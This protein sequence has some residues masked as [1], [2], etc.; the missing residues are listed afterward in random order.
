MQPPKL[1]PALELTLPA[2]LPDT[3]PD[4]GAA[5]HAIQRDVLALY[6]EHAPRLCE[7]GP[8]TASSAGCSA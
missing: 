4:D 8:A 1:K 2:V 5:L 7:A 3:I 6:D